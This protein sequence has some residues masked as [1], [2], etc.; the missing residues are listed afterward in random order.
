[1]KLSLLDK[2]RIAREIG[3]DPDTTAGERAAALAL[4]DRINERGTAKVGHATIA[5]EI[6]QSVRSA[7]YATRGLIEKRYFDVVNTG[8]G[9]DASIYCVPA[10]IRLV[11]DGRTNDS[12]FACPA[13]CDWMPPVKQIARG[14]EADCT[15][16]VKQVAHDSIISITSQKESP[17]TPSVV[18]GID[19]D[20]EEELWP[21]WPRKEGR[22]AALEKYRTARKR[23]VS[24]ADIM[25]GARRYAAI[26]EQREPKYRKLLAGWLHDQRWSDEPVSD[27]GAGG[28]RDIAASIEEARRL[29]AGAA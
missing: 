21:I 12:L 5:E 22:K 6:G 11:T 7:V 25:D 3:A 17:A 27:T 29:K 8:G 9:T 4:L 18:A 14:R 24:H 2:W 15:G 10:P 23:G 13:G 20:F 16:A 26:A 28:D 1:V 19:V